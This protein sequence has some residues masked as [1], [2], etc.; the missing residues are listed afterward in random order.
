MSITICKEYWLW[1][2]LITW[3]NDF[4]AVLFCSIQLAWGLSH[5]P[6]LFFPPVSYLHSRTFH[7]GSCH[8]PPLAP[9]HWMKPKIDPNGVLQ[10]C[11]DGWLIRITETC[12]IFMISVVRYGS[13]WGVKVTSHNH[14][15]GLHVFTQSLTTTLST[16]QN[17]VVLPSTC[18]SA[19]EELVEPNYTL[20]PV[21]N[22]YTS[23]LKLRTV[24]FWSFRCNIHWSMAF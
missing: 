13:I 8:V 7:D 1:L 3:W 2:W 10:S 6:V 9:A 15:F 20:T 11:T 14:H 21:P 23:I 22:V 18:I 4:K 24:F 16:F 5:G 17:Y 19:K 12:S